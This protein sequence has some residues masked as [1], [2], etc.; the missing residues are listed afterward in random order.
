MAVA[1]SHRQGAVVRFTGPAQRPVL[2]SYLPTELLSPA[3]LA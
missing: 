1:A 2:A 3:P